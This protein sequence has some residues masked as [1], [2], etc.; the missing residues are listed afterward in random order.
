MWRFGFVIAGHSRRLDGV[1]S[2]AYAGNPSS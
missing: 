2:L 1:A